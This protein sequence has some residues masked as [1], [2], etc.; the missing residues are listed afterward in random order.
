VETAGG[1]REIGGPRSQSRGA[2]STEIWFEAEGEMVLAVFRGV[3][4]D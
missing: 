4:K 1:G 3:K 2:K